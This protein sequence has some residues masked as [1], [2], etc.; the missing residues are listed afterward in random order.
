[1][2]QPRKYDDSAID[3]MVEAYNKTKSV[4]KAAKELGDVSGQTIHTQITNYRPGVLV[5]ED[6][7][8]DEEIAGLIRVYTD[9]TAKKRGDLGLKAY[10]KEIGKCH[11][12]VCRKARAFGLTS[13]NRE[14]NDRL[15]G[16]ISARARKW[17]RE[18][19]HPRGFLHKR[20]SPEVCAAQSDRT[21]NLWKTLPSFLSG[22]STYKALIT[23]YERYGTLISNT[24]GRYTSK[25]GDRD[26]YGRIQFFRSSWEANYARILE[27]MKLQ[28][29]IK[30]W[31]F[32]PDIFWFNGIKRGCRTYTPDFKIWLLDKDI[33]EDELPFYFVEIKGYMDSK[34]AT[35]IKRFNSY[36]PEITLEVVCSKEYKELVKNYASVLPGWERPEDCKTGTTKKRRSR[37]ETKEIR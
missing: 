32:E 5:D 2:A 1:M 15:S 4:W 30:D 23:K 17:L 18:N 11:T 20:H 10:A 19:P 35:K 8:T 9:E 3:R 31:D 33:G 27:V 34:S 16:D 25:K 26:I 6:K 29:L 36:F 37:K 22:D 13:P 14:L 28:G 24:E 12:N 21:K 7:W